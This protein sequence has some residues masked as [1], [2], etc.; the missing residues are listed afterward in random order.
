MTLEDFVENHKE[1]EWRELIYE[2]MKNQNESW[3][4]VVSHTEFDLD[5]KFNDDYGTPE[6]E[7][8]TLWTKKRVYFP[9]E[10]DGSERVSS[11]PRSPRSK[12]VTRHVG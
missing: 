5:R 7:P 1:N 12:E 3:A 2:E 11:V 6:G 10:Y 4:D 9:V 8:F